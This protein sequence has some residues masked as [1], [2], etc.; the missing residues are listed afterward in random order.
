MT[1]GTDSS[2]KYAASEA[3]EE[4][5]CTNRGTRDLELRMQTT[6]GMATGSPF[7]N[8]QWKPID[9]HPLGSGVFLIACRALGTP[10]AARPGA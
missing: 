10:I 1:V 7:P 2:V 9:D 4:L 5:D 6:T 3:R 8:P